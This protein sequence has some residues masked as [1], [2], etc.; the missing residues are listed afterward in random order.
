MNFLSS[1][2]AGTLGTE[3][4]E[5]VTIIR[6]ELQLQTSL[7]LRVAWFLSSVLPY[8]IKRSMDVAGALVGL[9]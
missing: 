6:D 5:P 8:S 2:S 4:Y 9:I 1:S 3:A 7:R